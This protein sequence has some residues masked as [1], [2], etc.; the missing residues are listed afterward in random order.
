MKGAGQCPRCA[1]RRWLDAASG[2]IPPPPGDFYSA[3]VR[4]CLNCQTIW[5]PV[6]PAELLDPAREPLGAFLHPC[7]NCAFRKGSPEQRDPEEF[8][9]LRAK[10]GWRG[11]RFYCHKG[12][13]VE[14]DSEDGFAYPKDASGKPITRKMRLCRGY[15]NQ[16]GSFPLDQIDRDDP[17]EPWTDPVTE[18]AI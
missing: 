9:A 4:I 11:A 8:A 5:E 15:L 10:L 6:D 17:G 7:N 14:P 16:L 2:N 13:P 3:D 12:V 1:S 18:A